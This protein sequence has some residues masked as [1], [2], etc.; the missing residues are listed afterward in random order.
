MKLKIYNFCVNIFTG[1]L[2]KPQFD[3]PSSGFAQAL[4]TNHFA[5]NIKNNNNNNVNSSLSH[6]NMNLIKSK[7]KSQH[8]SFH[9][10]SQ[11]R[12]NNENHN[13]ENYM[14][15]MNGEINME[16]DKKSMTFSTEQVQCER[17][18]SIMHQLKVNFNFSIPKGIVE[19][20]MQNIPVRNDFERLSTFLWNLPTDDRLNSEPI[21]RAKA[22]VAYHQGHFHDL[23]NILET[24]TFSAKY[25]T[26]LQLL[27]FKGH[28]REAEKIRGR[29]LGAVDKYRLRKKYPLPKTIW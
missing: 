21:L 23:Y 12:E 1:S 19:A 7:I 14:H 20:L 22:L 27:W 17:I 8:D 6:L 13:D 15:H 5:S 16:V 3:P 4:K 29:P 2:A 28:Y 10:D 24:N 25:H 11:S 9:Y 26:D 18:Y